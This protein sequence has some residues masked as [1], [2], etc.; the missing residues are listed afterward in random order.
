[1]PVP[2]DEALPTAGRQG[3]ETA[4]EAWPAGPPIDRATLIA[5]FAGDAGL[6]DEVAAIFLA[7]FPRMRGQLH[8]ACERRD[9]TAVRGAAHALKGAVS[10]FTHGAPYSAAALL[11]RMAEAGRPEAF[12]A[13]VDVEWR[14]AN[15]VA[16]IA[17]AHV[18]PDTQAEPPE[19]TRRA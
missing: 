12:D 3:Q 5:R 13:A 15:L 18:P 17:A 9:L 11:E 19:P 6:F 16:M 7:D 1:M 2:S 14:L 8:E 4:A 10:H